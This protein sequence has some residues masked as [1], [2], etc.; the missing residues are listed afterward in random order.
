M[1][2]SA[3]TRA[4][5]RDCWMQPNALAKLD[6][7]TVKR[8]RANIVEVVK[9]LMNGGDGRD[10][11]RSV[12]ELTCRGPDVLACRYRRLDTICKLFLTR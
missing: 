9:L 6:Q 12:V 3:S 7:V 10:A 11:R 1:S 4:P 8:D 2:G 5:Y